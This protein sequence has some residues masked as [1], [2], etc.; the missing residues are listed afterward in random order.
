MHAILS[1]S[2][3]LSLLGISK[4]TTRHCHCSNEL[5]R[6]AKCM[7]PRMYTARTCYDGTTLLRIHTTYVAHRRGRGGGGLGGGGGGGAF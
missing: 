5:R 7:C 1:I 6:T 4:H 2:S 3:L